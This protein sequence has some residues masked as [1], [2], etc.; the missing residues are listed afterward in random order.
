MSR[1]LAYCSPAHGHLFPLT[2]VLEELRRRGHEI[3]L[4]A[5]S[6]EVEGMRARGFEAAPIAAEIEAI[7]TDDWKARTPAGASARALRVFLARAQH[8]APDLQAAIAAEEPDA[9]LV[10]VLTWGALGAAEAWG[11]PWACFCPFPLPLRSRAGPPGGL[12]LR[13]AAGPLGRLRDTALRPLLRRGFDR[14]SLR[15]LNEG[16]ARLGLSAL[17]HTEELFLAPPLLIYMS[18]EPFEYPRPDWP[19]RIVAVGPCLWEPPGELP[20]ALREVEAPLV[21]VT[22]STEFQDDGRLVRVAL[23]ALAGEPFHVV[24]TLP[25]AS[26]DGLSVPANATVLRFAPHTPILERCA[27][28]ITHGGMGATQKA[29]ALGVP[30]CA[31][32]FGRDQPEVARRVEVAGA[33]TRLP[34]SRLRPDRLRAKVQEAVARKAG[35]ERVAA[36]FAAAGGA[37][38][39]ADAFEQL[40]ERFSAL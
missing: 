15:G 22:S 14:I 3:V 29:L 6:G 1:V 19:E 9:L 16:R 28:A 31:V 34:A 40:L 4:R 10:D 7:E 18:A 39:A 35:A 33:G 38:A 2:A 23:E 36:G 37:A 27:C 8:D 13:P 32:P 17:A 25:A 26:G 20:A 11:G 12:G 24:A 5:L 30:V 21:L